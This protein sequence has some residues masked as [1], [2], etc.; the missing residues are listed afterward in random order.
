MVIHFFSL[1]MCIFKYMPF[2]KHIEYFCLLLLRN[3]TMWH[4]QNIN[5]QHVKTS[6]K[7]E[8]VAEI[9]LEIISFSIKVLILID[10]LFGWVYY[11][12][13]IQMLLFSF[14]FELTEVISLK[15]KPGTKKVNNF[16]GSGSHFFHPWM[17]IS[18]WWS[19][20]FPLSIHNQSC[21]HLC[22]LIH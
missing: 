13:I 19:L 21:G 17:L 2:H 1:F 7:G 18:I 6:N 22:S 12:I 8:K 15:L 4:S 20:F 5:T 16:G 11:Q 10:L 3:K 14:P 9:L